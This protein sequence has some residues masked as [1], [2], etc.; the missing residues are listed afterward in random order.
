[1]STQTS[2]QKPSKV[3]R[4]HDRLHEAVE[5]LET[6]LNN[7]PAVSAPSPDTQ[8]SEQMAALEAELKRLKQENAAL[9]RVNEQVTTR[10]DAAIGRLQSILED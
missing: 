6:A 4:A 7:A 1:M 8:N 10:L 2:I 5:R 9:K 3:T